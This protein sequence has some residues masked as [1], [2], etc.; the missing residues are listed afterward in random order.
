MIALFKKELLLFTKNKIGI[1]TVCLLLLFYSLILFTDLF[2][3]NILEDGYAQLNTFFS[4]SPIIFLIFISAISMRSFSEEYK[5]ETIDILFSKP[6]KKLEIVLA[7]YLSIYF[8]ILLSIIPT[9]VYP[10]TIYFLGED[11]G[12]MDVA[13]TFGSYLGLFFLCSVFTAISVFSS[14]LSSNQLNSFIVSVLLNLFFLYGFDLISQIFE[15]GSISLI[16]QK[17]G[18]LKHFELLSKG[19]ISVSDLVYFFSVTLL[20]IVLCESRIEK[21]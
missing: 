10:I 5:N 20:F 11:I 12:N 16:I 4:L 19:L 18:I 21:S 8:V 17:F 3:L 6:L 2:N 13:A 1:L 7:K 14:S 15:N 9:L